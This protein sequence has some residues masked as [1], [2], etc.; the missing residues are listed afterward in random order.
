ME[1][2]ILGKTKVFLKYYNEEFLSRYE[3]NF[4]GTITYSRVMNNFRIFNK[5]VR[6]ASKE[7]NK[8]AMHDESIRGEKKRN[9]EQ[10]KE[11]AQ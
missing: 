4:S 8:G 5:V 7:D 3:C 1:G 2:W 11:L 10:S 6:N 9:Q